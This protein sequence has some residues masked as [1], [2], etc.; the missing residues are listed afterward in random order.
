MYI[1]EKTSLEPNQDPP[2]NWHLQRDEMSI[3]HVNL[4]E[5]LSNLTR[6]MNALA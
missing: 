1:E 4:E 3:N 2:I 5:C 6:H